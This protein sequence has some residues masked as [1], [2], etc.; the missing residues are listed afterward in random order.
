ERLLRLLEIL[1][2]RYQLVGGGR[3]GRLEISCA[4][5][6]HRIFERRCASTTEAAGLLK[7]ILPNDQFR[8]DFRTKEE[9]NSRKARYLLAAL[10][11]QA[12]A[13]ELG[14]V[15]AAELRPSGTL[16][17]KHVFPRS[18]GEER[19]ELQQEE[20]PDFAED[21]TY[22]LG[23]LCLLTGMNRALGNESFERKKEVFAESDLL[24]THEIAELEEWN[25]RP[26][27]AGSPRC[28]SSPWRYGGWIT[29][30]SPNANASRAHGRAPNIVSFGAKHG[31][32]ALFSTRSGTRLQACRLYPQ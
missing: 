26:W 14:G 28:R 18:P 27:R 23:N 12:R 4:R 21:C 20:D 16:T 5:L 15:A 2:V 22:R 32:V 10:E 6:A 11:R 8:E 25:R 30:A 24:T 3:T 31:S 7:D 13:A 19:D 17:L 9:K 29:D 1:I